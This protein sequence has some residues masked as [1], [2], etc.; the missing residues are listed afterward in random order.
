M[1]S[2]LLIVVIGVG[3]MAPGSLAAA[4]DEPA[5]SSAEMASGCAPPVS[6]TRAP[7]ALRV[8]SSQNLSA[9]STF[10]DHDLLVINGGTGAGLQ[11]G[12]RFFV[13]HNDQFGAGQM[14]AAPVAVVTDGWIQIVSV[15]ETTAIARIDHVCGAIFQDDYL[16]PYA[17][18]HLPSGDDRQTGELDFMSPARIVSGP[19]GH[20]TVV[21]GEFVIV[22]RGSED[23]LEPGARFAIY[24]DLVDGRH[25]LSAERGTPLAAVG[26][27]IVVSTDGSRARARILQ[28]RD[29]VLPGDYAVFRR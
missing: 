8:I 5:L 28:S 22:D 26:E 17:T 23:K 16:E 24:R 20:T 9:R 19:E 15:N 4:Q 27:G 12:S 3:L 14:Y 25:L 21:A 2:S 1:R 13:R 7:H 11:L 18:P 6:D 10:D 29:A